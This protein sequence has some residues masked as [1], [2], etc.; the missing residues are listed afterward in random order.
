MPTSRHAAFQLRAFC[1]R[2]VK[3]P[4]PPPLF[5][6]APPTCLPH[7]LV[8]DSLNSK[9]KTQQCPIV[10][11]LCCALM[12]KGRNSGKKLMAARIVK[13]TLEII[14]LLTDQNPVQV[15]TILYCTAKCVSYHN[16][17]SH[18][19]SCIISCHTCLATLVYFFVFLNVC[20]FSFFYQS[21]A[22]VL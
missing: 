12:R 17:T 16:Y 7:P 21:P 11:R 2:L 14:H 1:P 19:S 9:C 15:C 22:G 5:K 18:L 13:H 8:T 4:L 20:V 3:S 6:R 10:E